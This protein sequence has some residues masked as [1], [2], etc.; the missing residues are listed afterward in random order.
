MNKN[1]RGFSTVGVVFI[2]VIASLFVG[3]AWYFVQRSENKRSASGPVQGNIS[4]KSY[5]DSAKAYTV[6]YPAGWTVK[7]AADCCDGERKDYTKISRS[8]TIVPPA[9]VDV[10]GYGVNIQ[11][12]RTGSFAKTIEQNWKD[13][14]HQ[15]E[16]KTIG[17]YSAKYVKV[18]FKG[19]A[20]NYIDH[21]YLITHDGSSI[22]V[23]FREKYY[24][25]YPAEDWSATKDM[26]SF[27]R[28]LSS[29]TFL[30]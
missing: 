25:R 12:D 2:L 20:E 22:F 17:G 15:P 1:Q 19:D 5:T 23:T 29:V 6:R 4:M 8:V 7:E 9:R 30:H 18:V 10:H 26:D 24:H 28:V 13:N 3:A 14:N 11:A 21:N 27:N 16:H